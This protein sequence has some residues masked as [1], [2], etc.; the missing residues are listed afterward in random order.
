MPLDPHNCAMKVKLMKTLNPIAYPDTVW[1]IN[2][3][4]E[5]CHNHPLPP[6]AK[7]TPELRKLIDE[8]VKSMNHPT[9]TKVLKGT[10]DP[11]L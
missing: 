11:F 1:T 3:K 2:S 8:T 10:Q 4:K 7:L 9:P 6:Y 5:M